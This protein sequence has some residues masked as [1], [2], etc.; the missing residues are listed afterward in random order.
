IAGAATLTLEMIEEK[1][2]LDAI[3]VSVGGGSQAVGAMT[4]LRHV[5]PAT[6]VYAVQAER[7]SAARDSWRAGHPIVTSRADTF[8]DGLATRSAYALTF[9]A[10]REGLADFLTVTEGEI[11]DAVRL[12]LSTTHNLAEGAGAAS[13]AG[14]RKLA[15]KLAGRKIGIVLSGG[16]IDS[17]TLARVINREIA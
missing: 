16:N 7:A 9:P 15:T 13:L 5:K 14:L 3:V 11:A 4:V 1:P 10:L 6:P 12:L 2:D 17:A 8:A